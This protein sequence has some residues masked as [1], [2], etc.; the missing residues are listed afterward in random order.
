M[1]TTQGSQ[2]TIDGANGDVAVV[3]SPDHTYVISVSPYSTT[4]V[5]IDGSEDVAVS[6]DGEGSESIATAMRWVMVRYAE[7]VA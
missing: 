1:T 7:D 5:T 3:V 6:V 2:T 4:I